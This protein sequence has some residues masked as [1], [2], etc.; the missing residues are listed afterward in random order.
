MFPTAQTVLCSMAFYFKWLLMNA[1][2][3]WQA[4]RTANKFIIS[5]PT[6]NITL[7]HYNSLVGQ[8]VL[9]LSHIV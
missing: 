4:H 2:L 5:S 6:K 3:Q 7:T 8:K 1:K 9:L